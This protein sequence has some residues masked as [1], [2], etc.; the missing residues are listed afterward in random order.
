MNPEAVTTPVIT[1]QYPLSVP[2]DPSAP[3]KA[4]VKGRTGLTMLGWPG[5]QLKAVEVLGILVT[6]ALEHG[7]TP[8]V[9]Q[10]LHARLSVTETRELLIEVTDA[11]PTFSDFERAVAGE[12]GQGLWQVGQLGAS[13]DWSTDCDF[14]SKTVRAIM[15]PGRVDL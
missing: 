7:I 8:G 15:R 12:L 3:L 10:E 9:T 13:I 2:V 1:S 11:N 5:S 6:N 4:R 14:S